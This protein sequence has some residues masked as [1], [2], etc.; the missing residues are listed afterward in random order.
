MKDELQNYMARP[1]RY[2]NIDGTGEM[3]MGLMMLGYTFLGYVQA[4]LPQ[5]SM[6]RHGLASMLLFFAVLLL[7]VGFILWFPKAIKKRITW[8]RTGYV[9]YRVGG[10]A[11]RKALVGV[12][13]FSA[14]IAAALGCLR[15]LDTRHDW[16]SLAWM[17]N[18]AIF[19]AGY[20]FW[21]YCFG[22]EHS[23]KW[24][25][26]LF[27]ALGLLAIALLVPGDIVGLRWLMLLFIGLT[28]LG[29]GGATL[30]WYIRHTQPP[31][32]AAE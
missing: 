10:K 9:A 16:I 22:R 18:V 27:M 12:A 31:T 6:W 15:R 32:P 20:A 17:G 8:P 24:L 2:N 23:W 4:N 13:V 1:C 14:V 30:F 28:W 29:S 25:I 5:G 26:L 3:G 19:G 11:W 21:I 7:M